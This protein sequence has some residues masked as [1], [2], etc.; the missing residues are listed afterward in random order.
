MRATPEFVI[1]NKE[2]IVEESGTGLLGEYMMRQ[3]RNQIDAGA[4]RWPCTRS[5]MYYS[6]C[7]DFKFA[8]LY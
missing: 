3:S 5:E 4:C 6:I 2:A 7:L 8:R 1:S